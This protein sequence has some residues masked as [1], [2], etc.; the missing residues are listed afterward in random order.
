MAEHRQE[1]RIAAPPATVWKVLADFDRIADWGD[2]VDH[3]SAM[4]DQTEGVG[5]TRRIL[6]GSQVVLERVI[7]WEPDQRLA[8]EFLDLP[9]VLSSMVNTWQIEPDGDGSRVTLTV[10]VE[11]G[12]RPPMR[13]AARAVARR[14][15]SINA[16]LLAGLAARA[17]GA[18]S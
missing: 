4:T 16:G 14:V 3:S 17:E 1:R 12:P 6:A 10:T 13:L 8:Y 18:P 2:N 15:G 5:T 7:E 11:P 9:G